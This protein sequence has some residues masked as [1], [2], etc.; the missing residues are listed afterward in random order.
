MYRSLTL[1]ALNALARGSPLDEASMLQM[2]VVEMR[3]SGTDASD[4]RCPAYFQEEC[5]DEVEYGCVWT[6]AGSSNGAWCQCR[7]LLEPG[8]VAP[9]RPVPASPHV[10]S[11][12]PLKYEATMGR[13]P[14]YSGDLHFA[15]SV[16]VSQS[17]DKVLLSWHLSGLEAQLCATPPDG[18]GNACGIHIHSGST[19]DDASGVG[20]HYYHGDLAAD[21]WSPV[22]YTPDSFGDSTSLGTSIA[23]GQSLSDV[24]GR[25]VVVHDHTG[26]R[27]SCGIIQVP[28]AASATMARYPGYSGDLQFMGSVSVDESGNNVLLSWHLSGLEAQLCATPPEG[29]GNACGIHIHSGSTCDDASGVGG[30]YYHGDLASDPW[31]PVVYTPDAF[32]D[33]TSFGNYIAIGQSLSDVMGRAIV[34]HDHTGGRVGCGIIQAL[35]AATADMSSYPG[36]SGDLH[37]T[38]SVSVDQSGDNLLLSWHL[39]GLEAQLC[40]T[41]PEGVGNACGI[42]IHSGS[43]CDDASGVGGHYY[44]GDLAADPWSPVVYTPDA[45]GDSTT[46]GISIAIGQSLSDVLGRAIVVHDHTGARVAC[47]IIA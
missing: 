1:T 4:C 14:G 39:C 40:A 33:S 27:V 16:S 11:N 44:H 23:I 41:P 36:Y 15:G 26:G 19:C 47:G 13:Y 35:P 2:P 29:V 12:Q 28:P 21:P 9:P 37:F 24:L 31:S 25:A 22:V 5:E 7:E 42:H 45:F 34:V 43:T 3:Q 10:Q 20:G 17:E 38:G 32:G 46:F 18:V 8:W 30:H 6:D